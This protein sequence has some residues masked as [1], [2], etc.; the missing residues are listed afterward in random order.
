MTN[1]QPDTDGI[2]DFLGCLGGAFLLGILAITAIATG[3]RTEHWFVDRGHPTHAVAFAAAAALVAVA[4]ELSALFAVQALIRRLRGRSA[5]THVDVLNELLEIYRSHPEGFVRAHG[6]P[7]VR[8]IRHIGTQ[9]DAQGG[10][11][12]ML[13]GHEAFAARCTVDGAS[14]NLEHMWDGIGEWLG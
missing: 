2:K 7:H 14:R 3:A 11:A 13:E 8:R 5:A 6:G 12:R 1:G 10:M 9:L 4:L